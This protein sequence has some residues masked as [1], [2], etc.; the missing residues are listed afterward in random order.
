[1]SRMAPGDRQGRTNGKS[2]GRFKSAIQ[3]K[4]IR[5]E[6]RA[7]IHELGDARRGSVY[8][9][10][11]EFAPDDAPVPLPLRGSPD[12]ADLLAD[13]VRLREDGLSHMKITYAL[14]P[15]WPIWSAATIANLLR[16]ASER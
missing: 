2:T 6:G 1:M 15:K 8:R 14:Y 4:R 3:T 9:T 12:R 16:E 11:V 10:D 7:A 13:V 5:E